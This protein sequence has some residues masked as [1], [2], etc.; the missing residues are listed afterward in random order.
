MP[1]VYSEE[2][3]AKRAKQSKDWRARNPEKAAAGRKRERDKYV[4]DPHA[5]AIRNATAR[6]NFA[7][8]MKDPEF[9]EA[10]AERSRLMREKNPFGRMLTDLISAARTRAWE[11]NLDFDLKQHRAELVSRI[12]MRTCE[13]SGM[14]LKASKGSRSPNSISLDRIDP[15]KGYVYSN[16]RV[17]AW[18][19]N[20]AFGNWGS[21]EFEK[22]ARA[23]IARIDNA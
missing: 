16:I 1:R 9:R 23:W 20:A 12:S 4:S 5:R 11:M 2:Q 19:L 18:C 15:A 17:V 10:W 22:Y 8:K 13:L 21:E 6:L 14:P 7:E 3:R